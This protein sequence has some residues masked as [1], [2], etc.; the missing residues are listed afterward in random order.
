M[1]KA[2]LLLCALLIL[3]GAA[4]GAFQTWHRLQTERHRLAS[5]K[6]IV[7]SQSFLFTRPVFQNIAARMSF[8]HSSFF[9]TRKNSAFRATPI[10]QKTFKPDD[11]LQYFGMK[12]KNSIRISNNVLN[13]DVRPQ[14]LGLPGNFDG[15]FNIRPEQTQ[16]GLDLI[17]RK[18]FP[19]LFDLDFFDRWWIYMTAP[20]VMVENNMNFS[21]SDVTNPGPLNAPVRDVVTA[22]QNPDWNYLKI[23]TGSETKTRLGQFQVGMGKTFISEDVAHLTTYSGLSI[24]TYH[25]TKN[26]YMFE[27]QPGF[28]GHAGFIWGVSTQ[29]PL[30]HVDRHCVTCFF[31]NFENTYLIRNHQ[32]RTVELMN[33]EWSRYMMFRKFGEPAEPGVN[34]LTRKVRCSPYNYMD[35]TAG[36]RFDLKTVE[37]EIGFGAWGHGEERIMLVDEWDPIY[38]IAGTG[39]N[40]SASQS[41]IKTQAPNDFVFT[42]VQHSQIDLISPAQPGTLLWRTHLA[43]GSKKR[44]ETGDAFF[45]LGVFIEVPHNKT[46]YFNQW[47]AWFTFGGA[48]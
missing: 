28:N 30:T 46:T 47:G 5:G 41:T 6:R 9:D 2:F 22:F 44:G 15:T 42:P 25:S 48:L 18:T 4:Y 29:F 43:I 8:W 23:R 38:A 13:G 33:K 31:L 17:F 45:G 27:E 14:W 39:L 11:M 32:F 36:F 1:R 26:K 20:V 21:Q 16:F 35:F 37:A 24:P 34:V 12:Y 19:K 7:S 40:D 3:P 10:Y